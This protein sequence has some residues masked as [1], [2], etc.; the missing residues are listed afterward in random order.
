MKITTIIS[1]AAIAATAMLPLTACVTDELYNTSHPG[2]ATIAVTADWAELSDET[3][4]PASWNLCIG[5][6]TAEETSGTHASRHLF[7]P[8]THA[9]TAWN[10]AERLTVS[11]TTVTVGPD[12]DSRAG[13]II[14]GNPG[15]MAAYA[16]QIAAEADSEY[17][18]T[19]AMKQLTRRLTVTI[20]L[21]GN[22]ADEIESID[23]LMDGAASSLDFASGAYGYG[24]C[25]PLRFVREEGASRIWS[26]TLRLLGVSGEYGR[27]SGTL[28]TASG[29]KITFESDM[30]AMLSGFNSDKTAPL[31]VRAS[32]NVD[33]K[34]DDPDDPDD[35]DEP[36]EPE[37]PTGAGFTATIGG[38]HKVDAGNVDAH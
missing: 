2:H 25:V 31:A 11:G 27:V 20:E 8:G 35:P 1:A 3:L 12:G 9:I 28:L 23:A 38:W 21:T 30:S 13:A 37:K 26:A 17:E 32:I 10:N 7:E 14:C 18:H 16:G 29:E 34:P 19:A 4:R 15:W 33:K 36:D 24:A 6:Y 5:D 22:G